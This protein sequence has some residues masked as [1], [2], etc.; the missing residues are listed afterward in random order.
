LTGNEILFTGWKPISRNNPP[1]FVGGSSWIYAVDPTTGLR[2]QLTSKDDDAM[3]LWSPQH[4]RIAFLRFY[5]RTDVLED[6]RSAVMVLDREG[7]IQKL[8]P[9]DTAVFD[10]AWSPDGK[11]IAYTSDG[12]EEGE[13]QNGI[14]V[15]DVDGSD[16]RQLAVG[17][18]DIDPVWS[19][20]GKKVAFSRSDDFAEEIVT[21]DVKSG[22]V[23][24]VSRDSES[25]ETEP[26][27]SPD[28][29]EIAYTKYDFDD[30]KS[31]VYVTNIEDMSTRALTDSRTFEDSPVWSADGTEVIFSRW[32]GRRWKNELFAKPASGGAAIRLTK[33]R[34]RDYYPTISPDGNHIAYVVDTKE[35]RDVFILDRVTGQSM[36]LTR[37]GLEE[38]HLDW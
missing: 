2:T 5:R 16:V 15:V 18:A 19:P 11:Q 12:A 30:G 1:R 24:D 37:T 25:S 27:W 28:S 10:L 33:D 3:P 4:D 22:D 6:N 13:G 35:F 38:A 31:H 7:E 9:G 29:R 23:T 32:L 26:A 8:T 14:R 17:P 34:G 21:V 20:D 36:R